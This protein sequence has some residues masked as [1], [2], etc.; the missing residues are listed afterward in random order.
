MTTEKL[1]SSVE[2]YI[3][4]MVDKKRATTAQQVAGLEAT[5][6]ELEAKSSELE[7]SKLETYLKASRASASHVL[8]QKR[9]LESS[10]GKNKKNKV[11]KQEMEVE[12]HGQLQQLEAMQSSEH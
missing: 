11:Y 8:S 6:A 10:F 5:N 4:V 7:M 12:L 9:A 3:M 1:E 2:K